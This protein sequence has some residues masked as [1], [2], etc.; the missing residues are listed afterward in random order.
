M[1]ILNKGV[2][3]ECL[4]HAIYD[5]TDINFGMTKRLCTNLTVADM[6]VAEFLLHFTLDSHFFKLSREI[7]NIGFINLVA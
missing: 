2:F 3:V 7:K 6:P 5:K 4:L 1:K